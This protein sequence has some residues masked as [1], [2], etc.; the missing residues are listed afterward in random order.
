MSEL[1]PIGT[2]NTDTDIRSGSV[3]PLVSST[4]AKVVDETGQSLPA[5]EDG[6]LLIQGPQVMK[7]YLEDPEKT[8]ECL[9]E[10]RWLRTGDVAHYDKDGYIYIT[11]RIKELIKVNGFPVA[12]AELEA[13][14]LTHPAVADVAVIGIPDDKSQEA[15]RAYIVITE[16]VIIGAEDIYAWV[17]KRVVH[18][19]R[20]Q[21][22]IV[23]CEA[24]PKSASGKIL[25]RILRD[26]LEH[27]V[28]EEKRQGT[29]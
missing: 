20:L 21:G 19:K 2:F 24:I 22:G 23:F 11:D 16:G 26:E 15:P 28:L 29:S 3:G 9:S 1:S 12:P 6:E 14:L 10:S 5:F 25:R 13:L 4:F 27:A 18:Y 8:A 17:S 7:G